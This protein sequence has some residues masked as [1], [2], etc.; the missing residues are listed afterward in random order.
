MHADRTGPATRRACGEARET[1]FDAAVDAEAS[2][3]ARRVQQRVIGLGAP[4]SVLICLAPCET[5]FLRAQVREHLA[6]HAQHPRVLTP[7]LSE[8]SN[9]REQHSAER[10]V[11]EEMLAALDEGGDAGTEVLWPTAYAAPVLRAALDD[12]LDAVAAASRDDDRLPS[13]AAAIYAAQTLLATLRAFL[14]IDNGGLQ[15]VA[16]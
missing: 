7:T 16:L 3:C 12:A 9:D 10:R 4:V 13:L 5:P 14:A 8:G 15:Q 6:G 1:L 11:W 2:P